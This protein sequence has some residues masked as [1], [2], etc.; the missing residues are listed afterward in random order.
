ML[1]PCLLRPLGSG[2]MQGSLESV[3]RRFELGAGLCQRKVV[4]YDLI[5]ILLPPMVE[6]ASVASSDNKDR[7]VGCSVNR[8]P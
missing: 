8:E 1:S 3:D 5:I 7:L 4:K 6:E 2:I